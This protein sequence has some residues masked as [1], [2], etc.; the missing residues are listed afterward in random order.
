MGG[1]E[2]VL[3]PV[4]VLQVGELN[5][6]IRA[7]L[8]ED[9]DLGDLYV[10][11]EIGTCTRSAAGHRYLTLKDGRPGLSEPA[12]IKA[13][14]FRAA[15]RNLTF[16]PETGQRVI[17]HGRISFYLSRG[18]VQL[19]LDRL[20]PTGVG[21]L[22]V[23]FQQ[24]V[25]RLEAEGLFAP[26]RKRPLPFL[27]RRLVVVTSPRGAAVR[28]VLQV[29]GRRCPITEVVV[30]PTLV[31]G[32]GS[33]A[34]I[35]EALRLAEMAAPDVILLVRGGGS[36]EDLQAFNTEVV[37]RAVAELSHPV[38]TGVGH[39]TDTTVVDFV[40][41]LR[42]ATPSV[43]A[44]LAVPDL[45]GLKAEV[46]ARRLRLHRS[47][48]GRLLL[49]R[50]ALGRLEGRLGR[51]APRARVAAGR[52][53]LDRRAARLEA[54][55]KRILVQA[56]VQ[57]RSRRGLLDARGPLSRLLRAREEFTGR[58]G[59]LEALSPLRVLGRGYS[60]TLLAEAGQVVRDPSQVVP[61]D[62]LV[63]RLQR[64]SLRSTVLDS[65][66][67]EGVADGT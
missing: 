27:P 20:E 7:D 4:R 48:T 38:V 24:L 52:Q 11:A 30:V 31:Q 57:V 18:D 36:H 56:S 39:E 25:A 35:V 2:L 21:A 5:S 59:R 60:I 64:G 42:A 33:P 46:L 49:E 29:I 9:P 37:A 22:A 26:E 44:E 53:D 3:A 62:Q 51:L 6:L 54:A 15:G 28:D 65:K 61:G 40:S 34:A 1:G 10:E 47:G 50:Q 43:A 8:E 19:Y 55:A 16:E 17:A 14:L 13:V 41:D 45:E 23:A 63:T 67:I 66:R 32:E 58:V 12:S